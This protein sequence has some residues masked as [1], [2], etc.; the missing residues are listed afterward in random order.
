MDLDKDGYIDYKEYI[1]NFIRLTKDQSYTIPE[2]PS[3]EGESY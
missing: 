1:D 2:K 3:A